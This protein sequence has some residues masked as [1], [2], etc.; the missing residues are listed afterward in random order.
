MSELEE[1]IK[2][3]E[4]TRAQVAQVVHNETIRLHRIEGALA[5]CRDLEDEEK[6]TEDDAEDVGSSD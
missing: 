6:E 2:I 4:A 5:I 1:K 3:L